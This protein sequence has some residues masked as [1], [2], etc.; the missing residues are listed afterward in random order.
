M[1]ASPVA[2]NQELVVVGLGEMQITNDN[3]KVLACLGLGSCIGVS[4]YDPVVR[5]GAVVH[6]V[7][8]EGQGEDCEKSSSKYANLALP[9]M[10][11]EMEKMGAVKNRI[12]LKIVGGAK[13]INNVPVNSLL[14]IGS[15][16]ITAIKSTIARHNLVLKSEELGG[17]SGRSMWLHID[18]GVT[19][20]RTTANPIFE[21]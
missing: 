21:I 20:V 1:I 3:N 19:R 9:F 16:N 5:T 17:T 15:R 10:L 2:T 11:R 8:P 12:V 6:I 7:L 18:T 4:A 14:D 13:I